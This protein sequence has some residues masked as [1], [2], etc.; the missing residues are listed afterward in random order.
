MPTKLVD[1]YEIEFTGEPLAGTDT[2]AAYVAIFAPSDNPMHL[3]EICPRQR[4]AADATFT[5]EAA[6]QSEAEQAGY[7][8]LEELRAK[9]GSSRL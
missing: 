5:S 7:R 3:A 6:A 4:V 9:P 1:G 8:L 2:W